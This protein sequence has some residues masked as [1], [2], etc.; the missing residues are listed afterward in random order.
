MKPGPGDDIQKIL[1]KK[2]KKEGLFGNKLTRNY[3]LQLAKP[4]FFTA[5]IFLQILRT[6]NGAC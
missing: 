4:Y 6:L 2:A 1:S 5:Q 3:P